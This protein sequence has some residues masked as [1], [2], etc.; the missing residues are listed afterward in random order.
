MEVTLPS[1]KTVRNEMSL[2]FNPSSF[3]TTYFCSF[4][5]FKTSEFQFRRRRGI[6]PFQAAF[7]FLPKLD[8]FQSRAKLR[9]EMHC[10]TLI[11]TSLVLAA[12]AP[13]ENMAKTAKVI[14]S[15]AFGATAGLALLSVSR[16]AL[17]ST[18][19]AL[20]EN[21][22]LERT[23]LSTAEDMTSL[24]SK[25]E[26]ATFEAANPMGMTEDELL[27]LQMLEEVGAW[28]LNTG[29]GEQ[30]ANW[31]VNKATTNQLLRRPRERLAMAR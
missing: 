22:S 8:F 15:A 24:F 6:L 9:Q 3:P 26:G 10:F 18:S 11:Y 20:I 13:A 25:T 29:H 14:A 7:N 16:G 17:G 12:P 4:V 5:E 27:N 2:S 21:P 23:G 1:S 19:K 31:D 28:K 30:V